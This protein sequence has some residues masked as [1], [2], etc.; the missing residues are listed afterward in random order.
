MYLYIPRAGRNSLIIAA[1]VTEMV[2]WYAITEM[3]MVV[4]SLLATL[5]TGQVEIVDF[6]QDGRNCSQTIPTCSCGV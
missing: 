4:R 2:M 5:S 1:S 3:Q 6:Y